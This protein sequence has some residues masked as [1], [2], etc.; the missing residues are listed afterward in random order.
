MTLQNADKAGKRSL[1]ARERWERA[2]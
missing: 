2:R 1:F